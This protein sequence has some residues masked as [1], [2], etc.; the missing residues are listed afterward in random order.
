TTR[1]FLIVTLL[2]LRQIGSP[3]R[4]QVA[5]GTFQSLQDS[6]RQPRSAT[7]VARQ[8]PLTEVALNA[9]LIATKT[10]LHRSNGGLRFCTTFLTDTTMTGAFLSMRPAIH[11]EQGERGL[12]GL[13]R[14]MS[15]FSSPRW[16]RIL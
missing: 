9:I 5:F 13:P 8:M 16:T 3:A 11:L 12:R 15:R 1:T 6:A 4:W 10:R 14:L 7:A 2:K